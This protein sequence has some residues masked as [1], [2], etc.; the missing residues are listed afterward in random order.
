MAKKPKASL[1]PL[2]KFDW[3]KELRKDGYKIS[4]DGKIK[5]QVLNQPKGQKYSEK[6][7]LRRQAKTGTPAYKTKTFSKSRA[8]NDL[9]HKAGYNNIEEY[10]AARKTA[11]HRYFEHLVDEAD[12]DTGIGSDFERKYKAYADTDFESGT[13][14][15]FDLLYEADL[16][17][18]QDYDRYIED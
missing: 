15:E 17:D 3:K 6:I 1:S 16:A 9:A 4:N 11:K 8:L 18:E 12:K 2:K 7:L 5:K 10:F 13:D 14:E